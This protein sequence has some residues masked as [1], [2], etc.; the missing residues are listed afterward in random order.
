MVESEDEAETPSLAR[1]ASI[2]NRLKRAS[3]RA[4]ESLGDFDRAVETTPTSDPADPTKIF[5]SRAMRQ[6]YGIDGGKRKR[7][8]R[9]KTGRKV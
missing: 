7:K 3:T 2:A 9:L 6:R 4:K 5:G 1:T 8:N